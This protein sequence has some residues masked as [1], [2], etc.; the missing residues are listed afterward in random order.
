MENKK[1]TGKIG[2]PFSNGYV[3]KAEDV[4][5]E[6]IERYKKELGIRIG[7]F[8]NAEFDKIDVYK[9]S[10]SG[11]ILT[12][13]SGDV[14]HYNIVEDYEELPKYARQKYDYLYYY[15]APFYMELIYNNRMDSY[16]R[17]FSKRAIAYYD[18][19][20][21]ELEEKYPNNDSLIKEMLN[22]YMNAYIE[23]K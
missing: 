7:T 10:D 14:L 19:T 1:V 16:L 20:K 4:T 11:S 6:V 21:K 17:E 9:I 8:Y 13:E 3:S 15:D 12:E 5:D 2:N 18:T 23:N 22:E